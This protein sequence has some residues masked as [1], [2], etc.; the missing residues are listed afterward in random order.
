M[1]HQFHFD[2]GSQ[3]LLCRIDGPVTDESLRE[4]YRAVGK[5][6]EKI[7]PLAGIVDFTGVTSFRVSSETIREL[8]ESP[9]PLKDPMVPRC[10]VAPTDHIFAM[11][12]MFELQGDATRPLLRVVRTLA[13]AYRLLRISDPQLQPVGPIGGDEEA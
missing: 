10:I 13:E 2:P 3:L 6:V 8:A 7:Q 12:R 4:Y 9:P 11:A 5:Y 1:G